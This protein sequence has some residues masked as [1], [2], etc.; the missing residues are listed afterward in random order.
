MKL[1]YVLLSGVGLFVL[2]KKIFKYSI[3]IKPTN[4]AEFMMCGSFVMFDTLEELYWERRPSLKIV[5]DA[6]I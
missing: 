3:S 2:D 4:L 6:L 1:L 5:N